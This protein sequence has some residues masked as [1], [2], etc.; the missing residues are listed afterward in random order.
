G[1]GGIPGRRRRGGGGGRG[2]IL[3]RPRR[4]RAL[5]LEEEPPHAEVP[6]E[7]GR[8]EEGCLALAERDEM[9]GVGDGEHGVIAP[10]PRA[11]EGGARALAPERAGVVDRLEEAR[12]AGTGETVVE[13]ELGAALD[14][15]EP[16]GA[17]GGEAHAARV[18][19]G[20]AG[21][22]RNSVVSCSTRST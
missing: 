16:D 19:P 22:G 15:A 20:P 9:G 1:G 3:D 10:D 7:G 12:A 8:L 5:E 18:G 6:G 13:R 2:A 14:A 4:V 17:G 21:K 11:A